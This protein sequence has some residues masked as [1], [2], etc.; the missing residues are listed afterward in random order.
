MK[1][2]MLHFLLLILFFSCSESKKEMS[3]N[4]GFNKT[5]DHVFS[6]EEMPNQGTTYDTIYTQ[7][8]PDNIRLI[9]ALETDLE[10]AG[11]SFKSRKSAEI[12]YNNCEEN[13]IKIVSGNG[14]R[15]Y[16]AKSSKPEKGTEDFY[17]DFVVRVYEFPSKEDA[18]KGF[19]DLEKALYSRGNHCNGKAPEKLVMNGTEVYHLSTRAEMFRS[20]T[21]KYGEMIKNYH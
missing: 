13:S 17:P 18:G 5:D 10:K 6:I 21:E 3:G 2:N 15:E 8:V 16:F 1:K 20:Y 4:D 9:T 11:F 14:I 7:N 12:S 19:K